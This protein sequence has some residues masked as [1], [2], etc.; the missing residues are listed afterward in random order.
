MISIYKK[1]KHTII[2]MVRYFLIQK[3]ARRTKTFISCLV[4]SHCH[5]KGS[6]SNIYIQV[7]LFQIVLVRNGTFLFSRSQHHCIHIPTFK[8]PATRGPRNLSLFATSCC[9]I[10]HSLQLAITSCNQQPLVVISNHSFHLAYLNEQL[11]IA[12]SGC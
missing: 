8:N 7:K 6:A 1:D 3:Q 10:R 9:I 4:Y 12:T 11:L 2:K 5:I